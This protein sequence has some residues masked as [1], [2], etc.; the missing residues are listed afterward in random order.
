MARKIDYF[1][2]A[3]DYFRL[4]GHQNRYYRKC[5]TMSQPRIIHA[6]LG[7]SMGDRAP[8]FSQ[9]FIDASL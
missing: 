9:L 2:D 8:Y 1:S 4:V 7:L 5:A 3:R 6:T